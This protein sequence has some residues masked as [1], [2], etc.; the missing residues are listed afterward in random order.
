MKN[1]RITIRITESQLLR[2]KEKIIME[3]TTKSKLLRE[4]IDNATG[5][6]RKP[7]I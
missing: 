6:C 3:S 2:L 1:K 4:I 7:S 5:F